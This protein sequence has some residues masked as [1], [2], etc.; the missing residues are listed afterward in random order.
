[1]S[2]HQTDI[3]A[4]I[5]NHDLAEHIESVAEILEDIDCF[6]ERLESDITEDEIF[7]YLHGIRSV[8]DMRFKSLRTA[9]ISHKKIIKNCLV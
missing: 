9:F 6:L 2:T 1:M 4:D 3:E 5:F 8:Y 7:N